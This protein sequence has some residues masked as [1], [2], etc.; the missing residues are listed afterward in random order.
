M[1][2]QSQPNHG[3]LMVAIVHLLDV[4]AEDAR[5][6][7]RL[8]A[9]AAA[10]KLWKVGSYVCVLTATLLR[11]HKGSYLD[12][13]GMQKHISKGKDGIPVGLNRSTVLTEEVCLQLPHVTI[14]LLGK[15]KGKTGVD[16][17]LITVA[18]E[19]S[20]GLCPRWGMEKLITVCKYKRRFDGLAFATPGGV[21][22]SSPDY[23]LV[24]RKY[25]KIVQEDT[26]LIPGDHDVD[27]N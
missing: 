19:T 24:F 18:N 3:L 13:A 22:A 17:H 2:C 7:E 26:D 1:G 27:T 6:V 15:F 10:D 23:D 20:S 4:I 21:L 11:G 12:L 25:L 14:C 16:H 5:E 9:I 8:D